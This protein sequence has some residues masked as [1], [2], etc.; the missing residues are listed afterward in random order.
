MQKYYNYNLQG[1]CEEEYTLENGIKRTLVKTIYNSQGEAISYID[2]LGQE[3]KIIIDNHYS[4]T[5]GQ[6][7]LKKTLINPL[8]IQTEMEFD[9]LGRLYSLSKKDPFGFLLSSQKHLYDALGNKASE[10]H[11]QIINGKIIDSQKTEWVYGPMGRL[12]EET[13]AA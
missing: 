13:Q 12:E 1:Q 11:D 7:V 8:G 10:I 5:L 9:A 4:N 6:N 3:T 2:G